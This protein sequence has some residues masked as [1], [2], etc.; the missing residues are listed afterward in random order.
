MRY[1][2]DEKTKKEIPALKVFLQQNSIDFKEGFSSTFN[3][4]YI[5]IIDTKKLKEI[6][7]ENALNTWYSAQKSHYILTL[8]YVIHDTIL[9]KDVKEVQD[10][11]QNHKI[12]CVDRKSDSMNAYILEIQGQN[13][14]EKFRN[15]QAELRQNSNSELETPSSEIAQN[16]PSDSLNNNLE[17][18]REEET[19]LPPSKKSK[20]EIPDR[21]YTEGLSAIEPNGP[22]LQP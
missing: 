9:Y 18:N 12:I 3:H 6:L 17:A 8:H 15:I 13:N 22:N 2:I 5:E 14:I 21:L 16:L 1:I 7:S 20:P 4:N 11:L 19:D 10:Y